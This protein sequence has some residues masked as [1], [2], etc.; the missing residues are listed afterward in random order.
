MLSYF[1]SY[2]FINSTHIVHSSVVELWL[3]MLNTCVRTWTWCVRHPPC[4]SESMRWDLNSGHH[5]PHLA[6]FETE[7]QDL[8]WNLGREN[9]TSAK[10]PECDR[11]R[12]LSINPN[13]SSNMYNFEQSFSKCLPRF[14]YNFNTVKVT[15]SRQRLEATRGSASHWL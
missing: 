11:L 2:L 7:N 12:D 9:K 8:G 14:D 10:S 15:L 5:S 3:R 6:S 4:V 13:R 1:L